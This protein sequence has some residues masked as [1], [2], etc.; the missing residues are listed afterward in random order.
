MNTLGVKVTGVLLELHVICSFEMQ[1]LSV[2]HVTL[3]IVR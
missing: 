3:S 1:Q 2:L